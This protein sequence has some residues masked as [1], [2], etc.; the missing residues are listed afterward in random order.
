M[1]NLYVLR[2]DKTLYC[3]SVVQAAS[4]AEMRATL[5]H[6]LGDVKDPIVTQM[7][8]ESSLHCIGSFDPDQM[9]ITPCQARLVCALTEL[10]FKEVDTSEVEET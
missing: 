1:I 6:V 8:K 3:G 4:D 7:I 5:V 2:N 9:L 10:P